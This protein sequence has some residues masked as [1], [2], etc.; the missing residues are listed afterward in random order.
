MY[1]HEILTSPDLNL[2]KGQKEQLKQVKDQIS[3]DPAKDSSI[4]MINGFPTFPVYTLQWKGLETVYKKTSPAK[5]S[6]T[7]YKRILSQKY[8]D[9]NKV[10]IKN[11]IKNGKYK[12]ERFYR[13]TVW[14]ASRVNTNIFT[15]AKKNEDVIQI[16]NENGKFSADFDYTGMLF[17]T[18]NGSRVS[19]QEIVFELEKIYDD[20][21]FMINKELRKIRGDT[22]VYDD[23]YLP[24]D[25]RFIDILHSISEDGVIRYNSSAEGN[26]AAM[27]TESNKVG[28]DICC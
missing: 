28:I 2:D 11:D 23:A 22:L 27:E 24:K 19:I 7:P 13:Q 9:D 8:F 1:Y 21:R 20:I 16:L 18:V 6:S 10:K 4:E 3:V 17:S 25:K 5:G 14:T 15:P 26:R 12:V